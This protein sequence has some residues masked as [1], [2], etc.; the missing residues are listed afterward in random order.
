MIGA[1]TSPVGCLQYELEIPINASPDR[2]WQA[3]FEETNFWWL[4]DFHMAGAN[5][6]VTFDPT[7]GGKGLI[8]NHEG[9]GGLLWYQVQYCL[10]H[11]YKI[12]LIGY[13]APDFGGPAT[14]HLKLMI[15]ST[16]GGCVLK[17]TDAQ[18]G[19]VSEKAAD[20]QREGWSQLFSDGLKAYVENDRQSE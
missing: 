20:S 7:P 10:P 17:V 1:K 4:P 16:D 15:E 2:V 19:S 9:G 8:E 5:S 3:M 14:S 18:T 11:D 13:L 12:Y 6:V